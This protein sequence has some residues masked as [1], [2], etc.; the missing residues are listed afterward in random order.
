MGKQVID[1]IRQPESLDIQSLEH[2]RLLLLQVLL[3]AH[4][5]LA[6]IVLVVFH[7]LIMEPL[8][9]LQLLVTLLMH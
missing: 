3:C 8:L 7:L 5:Q 2:L 9:T 1:Y 4:Y 6:Q